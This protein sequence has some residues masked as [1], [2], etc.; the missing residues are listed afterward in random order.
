MKRRNCDLLR[1]LSRIKPALISK[2][3]Q[4]QFAYCNLTYREMTSAYDCP[5]CLKPL[6]SNGKHSPRVLPCGH[7]LCSACCEHISTE[8]NARL[9]GFIRCPIC[10]EKTPIPPHSFTFNYALSAV[11][12]EQSST[13][14]STPPARRDR[15]LNEP[16]HVSFG[17]IQ[18]MVAC[19]SPQASC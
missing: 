10:R 18:R 2:L 11:I 7:T 17:E 16:I 4:R 14:S 1:L 3:P 5:V 15:Y 12:S 8:V 19:S 6:T 9:A 13:P